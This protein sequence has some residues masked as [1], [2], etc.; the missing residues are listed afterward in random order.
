MMRFCDGGLYF[1]AMSSGQSY[2]KETV[3]NVDLCKDE[4]MVLGEAIMWW[5]LGVNRQSY[6]SKMYFHKSLNSSDV[7]FVNSSIL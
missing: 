6:K 5:V 2:R 1:Q 3:L 7:Q 4:K